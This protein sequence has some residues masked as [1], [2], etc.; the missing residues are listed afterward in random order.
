MDEHR[1]HQV[2]QVAE[3]SNTQLGAGH[4]DNFGPPSRPI[5][6]CPTSPRSSDEM[7]TAT[8]TVEIASRRGGRTTGLICTPVPERHLY[9]IPEA[10]Q[11]L[12][13]SR[14]VIYEQI[15]SGRLRTVN[16]GRVRLVPRV[17]I[18][19]YVNLLI[20]ES[21]GATYDKAS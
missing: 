21:E 16:Q 4:L 17:A 19:E 15:R 9:R 10:M 18:V 7:E 14:S 2:G 1:I 5:P 13:M 20:H 6:A 3:L 8:P 11:L 12:S